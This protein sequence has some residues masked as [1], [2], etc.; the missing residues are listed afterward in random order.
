MDKHL[1]MLVSVWFYSLAAAVFGEKKS[2]GRFRKFQRIP[3]FNPN[4]FID[5]D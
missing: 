3:G 1:G 5:V 2:V 4:V